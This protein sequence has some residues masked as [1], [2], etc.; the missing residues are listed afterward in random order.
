MKIPKDLKPGDKLWYSQTKYAT[1]KPT[2]NHINCYDSDSIRAQSEETPMYDCDIFMLADGTEYPTG[3][4]GRKIIRVERVVSKPPKAPKPKKKPVKKVKLNTAISL[5]TNIDGC[6]RCG[7]DH[8][9]LTFVRFHKPI[10]EW[11][12]RALCPHTGE[13]ILLQEVDE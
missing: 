8:E 12:Y 10:G 4:S 13:P 11:I 5:V 7:H 6:S 2:A 1:V 3:G 9:S